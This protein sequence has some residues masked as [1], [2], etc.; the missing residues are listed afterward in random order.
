MREIGNVLIS[1]EV[2]QTRFACNLEKCLGLCCQ[3]GDLGAP[4]SEEEEE[5]IRKNLD[6]VAPLL[7]KQN[8]QLLRGG[9]SER[10][11]GNLHIV[12]IAENTPC[13]LSFTDAE[14]IVLC[15]LHRYAL[16]NRLPLLSIKPLWCSLFPLIIKK[17]ATGWLINCHIP[18]FCHSTENP[19]PLLLSFADLL[20]TLFGPEWLEEVKDAYR[21]QELLEKGKIL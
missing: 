2:W 1:D 6:N 10:Y 7:K 19:Q 5:T 13:P 16:D 14:G 3:Y 21:H 8:L 9:I 18:D 12:E 17:T 4:L 15:S 20:V 11:K